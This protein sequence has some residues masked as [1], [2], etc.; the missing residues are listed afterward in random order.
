M[1]GR[2]DP[3][4]PCAPVRRRVTLHS[5]GLATTDE[6]RVRRNHVR[7]RTDRIYRGVARASG[8]LTLALMGLIGLFLVIRAWPAL[9]AAGL[10]FFTSI[11]VGTEPRALR[12]LRRSCSARS[13]SR[14]SR[15]SSRCPVAICS[16]LFVTEYAPARLRRPLTSFID[17]LAAIPSLIYGLWGRAFLQPR[18]STFSRWLGD[19]PR[20]HP[21]LP[22]RR[23]RTASRATRRRRS[24][25]GS[26]SRS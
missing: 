8:V 19:P 22:H 3:A 9:H 5:L 25:P 14:S 7:S 15:W 2:C 11:R 10:S 26:S 1:R 21:V 12:R 18:R 23:T 6:E 13:S 20:L 24:S 4:R 17:V 16:A